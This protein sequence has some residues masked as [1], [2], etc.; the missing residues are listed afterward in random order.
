M[1]RIRLGRK[2]AQRLDAGHVWVYR[3]EVEGE[4]DA[5]S[6]E[7]AL[8]ADERGRL[9]GS[10]LVDGSSAIPVR[11]FARKEQA[12]DEDLVRSRI[13]AAI[14]WRKQL[15]SPDSNGYRAVSSESDQL[16][17]LVIDRFGTSLALQVGMRNYTSFLPVILST[18]NEEFTSNQIL[19][20]AVCEVNGERQL[21]PG[22]SEKSVANYFLNGMEFE[23]DL[24]H[25]PKTGAF[26]DQR[27]NY[28]AAEAWW[29]RLGLSGKA[30]D[31]YSSSGGFAL[32][33]A[34]AGAAVDAV[35]SSAPA[36][37]RIASHAERNQ[38]AGVRAIASDVKQF[39]RG[40]GQARRRYE[41]VIA[42]PPAFAK[43]VRQREE[44]TRAYRDLNVRALSAVAPGGL[45]VSC[46]CSQ[47]ISESDLLSVIRDAAVESRKSLTILEKRGQSVDHRAVVQ[48]PETSYLKCLYFS[49][50]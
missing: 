27:E 2:A 9:L 8:L 19:D 42:D 38:L 37:A 43:Q 39:L 33:L 47:A 16:P 14:A 7:M 21:I 30:L 25:G 31:L 45:F 17:G 13:Q 5:T 48:I 34:R 23:A 10:A 22:D 50:S 1:R 15:V 6:L 18:L 4:I 44:A 36:V 3:G 40:L 28:L 49:V 26:L 35:D 29:R 32:H 11:L 41:C 24:L 20:C 12:F 46:S